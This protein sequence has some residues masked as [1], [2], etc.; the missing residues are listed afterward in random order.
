MKK[1]ALKHPVIAALLMFVAVVG[2]GG[3]GGIILGLV[4]MFSYKCPH[5]TANDPCDGGAMAGGGIA[6]LVFMA[7]FIAGIVAA[8]ATFVILRVLKR[9]ASDRKLQTP[10][11]VTLNG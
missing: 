9:R 2:L 11:P 4:V 6:T 1:L 7:S 3:F 10:Q 8:I 5:V